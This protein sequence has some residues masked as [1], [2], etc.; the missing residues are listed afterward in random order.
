M[1]A[2]WRLHLAQLALAWERLWPAFWPVTATVMVFLVAASFDVLPALPGF[3]HLAFL[4]LFAVAI[5][6]GCLFVRRQVVLPDRLAARRRIE[7]DSGLAHRPLAALDDRLTSGRD[8][9]FTKALWDAHRRRMAAAVQSLH[10]GWP[11][12]GLVTRDPFA[13]R[14]ALSLLLLIGLIQAGNDVW[15]RL[16]RAFVPAFGKS[17]VI[18]PSSADLWITPPDY[19]GLPPLYLGGEAGS[20]S[21]ISVP[22]GSTV[23]AQVHGGRRTP[24]LTLDGNA[25]EFA[26]LDAS[27]FSAT[28]KIGQ[29]RRLTVTQGGSTLE[30]YDLDIIPDLPPTAESSQPPRVTPRG[31]LRLDY[32]AK[33]DYGVKSVVLEIRRVG[34]TD[35]AI[36]IPIPIPAQARKELKGTTYQD[37]TPHPWAGLPVELRFIVRDAIDQAGISA[38]VK[39]TLP[40]HKFRH[41]IAK[42]IADQRKLLAQDPDQAD[43]AAE[44]LTDLASRPALYRNDIVAFLALRSAAARLQRDLDTDE[45]DGVQKLLWDTALRIDEGDQSEAQKSLRQAEQALQDALD[46]N[47][48]DAEINKLMSE[49]RQAI[50]RYLQAMIENAQRNGEDPAN[51]LPEASRSLSPDDIARLLNQTQQLSQS[52]AKDAAKEALAQLQ[53]LLESLR[54]GRQR[55]AD[56]RGQQMMK[57]MQGLAERQQQLLDR[58]Y[59]QAQRD[60]NGNPSPQQQGQGARGQ[61][62]SPTGQGGEAGDLAGAQE[63]LRR[64]LGEMMRQLGEN[65]EGA[66][67]ISR[68]ERA[69]RGAVDALGRNAPGDAVGPQG[70][71]LDQ[72]QQATR[73]LAEKMRGN[74]DGSESQMDQ[75]AKDPL[76]RAI[77][78]Q[79]GSDHGDVQ[80]PEESEMHRS[81]E[82]LDELRRRAADRARPQL[83]RDYIDRLLKRF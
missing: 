9:P 46:R 64:Q 21:P 33:D 79:G 45:I 73:E 74:G 51:P 49:L 26:A 13:L 18:G 19:T 42:A 78:G 38:P 17:A 8:D 48:P 50:N 60:Q 25:T 76:G 34:S 66:Q 39:L 75:A 4:L 10:L 12:A 61:Q 1:T 59:R 31:A 68:A 52:G 71:A 53:D 56:G 82:I 62:R 57:G 29:A 63:A 35:P 70:E 83:E 77:P 20:S 16:G 11:R 72:L 22:T 67:A 80:I 40:E 69:M 58:A 3:L 81:R 6:A 2:T 37:L 7:L 23:L 36:E 44:T 28:A 30:G 65:G 43:I 54:V 5:V 15:P 27:D 32:L 47:A 41:P 24:R 55:Q 14:A